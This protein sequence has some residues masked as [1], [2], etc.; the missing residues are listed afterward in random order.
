MDDTHSDPF[1]ALIRDVASPQGPA[2]TDGQKPPAESQSN[3]PSGPGAGTSQQAEGGAN[4][5]AQDPSTA[6]PA[7]PA[8]DQGA[9]TGTENPTDP[10]AQ[11]AEAGKGSL[12]EPLKPFETTVKAKGFDLTKPEGLA[13]VLQWGQEAESTLG[14]RTTDLNM[15]HTRQQEIEKDFQSGAEGVNRR[16]V[17]MGLSK[18]DIPT[19]ETRMKE[20]KDIY[21]NVSV[22]ANPNASP[23]QRDA[24]IDAL[25]G[26]V[27]EPMDTLRIRQAAG[28][29]NAQS[30]QAKLKEHRTNSASLFNQRTGANPELHKAYDA[31]LPD[32]QAGGVFNSF[33]LDEFSM[34][35][36]P[37]RA[38][39]IEEI[40]QALAWKSASYNPDGSVRDG[41]P[42]DVE[43]KKALAL[44]T[45]GGNA[46]PAGNGQPPVPGSN[47]QNQDPVDAMLSSWARE[48]AVA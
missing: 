14:R 16:L 12:P 44:A 36:S 11:A 47:A 6:K 27:Y 26:L 5:G 8:P 13:K 18:L 43:I 40:G 32:F 19:P 33:G 29:G 46:A 39:R 4:P 10:A 21:S 38:A 48:S 2:P 9:A 17:M 45:R 42:I 23:E 1:D 37:E 20:L 30:A 22:L 41:G 28:Q 35:S 7:N 24:A 3:A 31:I 34:T 15:L 25:N